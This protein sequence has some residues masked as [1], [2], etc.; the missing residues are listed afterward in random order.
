MRATEE[1]FVS[2]L[3]DTTAF[4]IGPDAITRLRL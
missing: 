3:P 2:D 4:E 1:W